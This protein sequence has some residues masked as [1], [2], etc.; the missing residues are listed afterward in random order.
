[1]LGT[2]SEFRSAEITDHQRVAGQDE[3]RFFGPCA[4]RYQ[5]ADMLGRV[6]RRMQHG[7]RDVAER[8]HLSVAHAFERECHLRLGRQHVFGAGRVSEGTSRREVIGMQM[9]IDDEVD[10]HAS[11]FGCAQIRLDGPGRIDD[12]TGRLAAAAEQIGD[13]D[14]IGVQELTEDHALAFLSMNGYNIQSFR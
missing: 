9:R 12:G 8:K 14:R 5:E 7:R 10:A 1:M 13:A 6:A 11:R 3:P 2:D 4:V